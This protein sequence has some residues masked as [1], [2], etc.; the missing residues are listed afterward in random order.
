MDRTLFRGS[1]YFLIPSYPFDLLI[2]F[3]LC[4]VSVPLQL[5]RAG[6]ALRCGVQVFGGA[7]PYLLTSQPGVAPS[8]Q[9][10]PPALWPLH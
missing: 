4:W 3:W 9:E 1:S 6:A 2:Y 10:L 8:R 5:R 7:F